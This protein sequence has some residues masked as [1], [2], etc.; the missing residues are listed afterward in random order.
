M[1]IQDEFNKLL[2]L[3]R[4][5]ILSERGGNL[6]AWDMRLNP[7]PGVAVL[8]EPCAK[9]LTEEIHTAFTSQEIGDQLDLLASNSNNLSSEQ[10]TA[11]E[12]LLQIHQRLKK[13][14]ADVMSDLSELTTK[15]INMHQQ[16]KGTGEF[17]KLLPLVY[18]VILKTKEI[19][20]YHGAGDTA[21]SIYDAI[22]P[23]YESGMSTVRLRAM[24]S[25]LRNH[26]VALLAQIK[27]KPEPRGVLQGD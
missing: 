3:L 25:R 4:P 14:P 7:S 21:E 10:K 27:E 26:I 23:D 6:N 15:A 16:G 17:E 20:G 13:V 5:I 24:F 12:R 11:V 22:L 8:A 19:A 9:R 18:E 1:A 2:S